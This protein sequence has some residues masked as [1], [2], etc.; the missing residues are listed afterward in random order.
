MEALT[1][2][3]Y[4]GDCLEV[5]R[6]LEADS[7]DAV[8]TDPPYDLVSVTKRF[9]G[10]GA[11]N[12][13]AMNTPEGSVWARKA[14]GFM[15]KTWDGTGIAFKPETWVECLRVAKPGAHLLAFGGTRTYH[16]LAAAIEDAGWEIRDCL[17]WVYATGFPKSL[18]VERAA[19]A[20]TCDQPRRHFARSLPEKEKRLI[21]DHVCS[22]TAKSAPWQGWGSA[23]KPSW[24]PVLMARKPMRGTTAANVLKHGTGAL[25]IDGTRIPY[26]DEEPPDLEQWKKTS[27]GWKNT[28]TAGVVPN[29]NRKGRWPANVVL[30]DPVFDGG[31]DDVV[32]GGPQ[33][34]VKTTRALH[35]H[36]VRESKFHM[37]G[38]DATLH[39]EP[40]GT[41]YSRFFI[42][43]KASRG[44]REPGGGR[45]GEDKERVNTH[46]TVK[47]SELMRHLVRLVTPPG[48]VV[49]DPFLGSGTTLLAAELEGMGW[50]GIE[51]E[52]EYV[53]IAEARLAAAGVGRL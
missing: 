1:R 10:S 18:D 46:P 9:G 48:G 44:D 49:L 51:S 38:R 33:V 47:P 32:G 34:S 36:A 12:T 26:V 29:D 11:R 41:T 21:N 43:P 17:V 27:G 28:S 39:A 6:S 22:T 8:V 53:E 25:N 7:V 19:A 52:L 37:G 35:D 20:A 23:M 13:P 42:I 50:V 4:H 16:R 30:T 24:E 40:S 45:K 3:L 2:L 31:W 15:G 14:R 5:M